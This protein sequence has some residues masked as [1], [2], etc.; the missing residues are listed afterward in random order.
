M[1][2]TIV[3]NFKNILSELESKELK[4]CFLKDRGIFIEDIQGNLYGIEIYRHGSYLDSLIKDGTI[5]KFNLVD[6]TLSTNRVFLHITVNRKIV[7]ITN[8]IK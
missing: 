8:Y 6:A 2:N 1:E 4:L 3:L 5:V 7:L